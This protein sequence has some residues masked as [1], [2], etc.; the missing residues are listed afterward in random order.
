MWYFA[1]GSN[2]ESA[3]L[4]GRRGIRYHRA[5]PGR[6][7]GWRLVL[8]KPGLFPTG[9]SFANIIPD[10]AAEVWG[11]LY[12]IEAADLGHIDLTEGVLIGNYLRVEIPVQPPLPDPALNAFALTS[13]RRDPRLQ[14]STR[15]MRLLISGAEEHGLPADYIA[16]LRGIPARPESTETAQLRPFID[17]ALRRR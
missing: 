1:Y 5:L 15:Y 7:P 14:P 4:R 8:D 9:N 6:A 2:M 12:H 11:V 16:F 13:E 3:T 17:E 10:A